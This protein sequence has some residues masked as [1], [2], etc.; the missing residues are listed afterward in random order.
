MGSSSRGQVL[1]DERE[2]CSSPED[3]A[4]D[5]RNDLQGRQ[6]KSFSHQLIQNT[7]VTDKLIT[8]EEVDFRFTLD[9]EAGGSLGQSEDINGMTPDRVEDGH[10]DPQ[11]NTGVEGTVEFQ[12]INGGDIRHS[13]V[14]MI[15]PDS[16]DL[17][18]RM[19][20]A[21]NCFLDWDRALKKNVIL[22]LWGLRT[23]SQA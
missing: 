23:T 4:I 11:L 10:A 15:E 9:N 18:F 19:R 20:A 3:L 21:I 8:T 2:S 13:N 6:N 12:R 7:K 1:A 16:D 17:Q 22:F 5:E 14:W